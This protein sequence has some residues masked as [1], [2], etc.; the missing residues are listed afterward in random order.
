LD[1][2]IIGIAGTVLSVFVLLLI[3]YGMKKI[4]L[5][6]PSN[7]DVLNTVVIYITLPAFI[8]NAIY[9]YREPITLDVARIPLI[10]FAMIALVGLIA[11]ILGRILRFEYGIIAGL[12][13][14]SSFGNT[15]FLGF[16]VVEAAFKSKEALFTA[17]LYDELAMALPLY[18]IG[19][20]VAAGFMGEK[21]QLSRVGWVLKLPQM[22][23]IPLAFL[24]RPFALPEPIL[25]VLKYL[26]NGTIPL[27]MI[28]LGL[29]ISA[30]SLKGY[31]LP[32]VIACILKLA[33]LPFLTYYAA[34]MIGIKGIMLQTLTVEAGMPTAMMAGVLVAKFGKS[35]KYVAGTIFITT[36][37]SLITIPIMLAIL[38]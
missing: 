3:G 13:L 34:K 27:V 23:A 29:S 5:L 38:K 19:M 28:S 8:F 31:T 18:T 17:V 37:M 4:R 11:Y 24:L 21:F 15:G 16:P 2:G 9:E 35:V 14:A 22:W 32:V 6:Q 30:K 7:C 25:A 10:G 36:M 1:Q 20:V 12:I 26:A 33:L